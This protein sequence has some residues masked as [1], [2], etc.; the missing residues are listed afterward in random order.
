MAPNPHFEEEEEEKGRPVPLTTDDV[1]ILKAYG[2]GPFGSQIKELEEDIK[3]LTKEIAESCGVTESDTGIAPQSQWNLQLDRMRMMRGAL[4]VAKVTKIISPKDLETSE[5]DEPANEEPE[6]S[7]D[8]H[9]DDVYM[10]SLRH[11]SKF[12]AGRHADLPPQDIDE[13]MRVG[14]DRA[15]YQIKTPLPPPIDPTIAM[16]EVEER[17]D[18]TY[19]D[20]G[21]CKEQL[22]QL[23]E[24]IEDPLLHPERYLALGIDPPKGVLLYG[25]P[26]TGKTLSARAVANRTDS[27]FI[28]VIGSE[29]VQRFIG[30]GARMVRELFVMARQHSP[31][32]IFIDEVDSIATKRFDSKSGG[33]RE[34]QRTMLELL[35]QMDGFEPNA[36]IK[37]IMATNRIDILDRALL[38]PG[39][40]DRKIE[41]PNP[42][43]ASRADI[44]RIHSRQMNVVR[45]VDLQAVADTLE[46]ASGADLKAVCTEAGMYALRERRI[47]ITQHDFELAAAKVMQKNKGLDTAL[48]KLW[49]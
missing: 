36:N 39:R 11:S 27:C 30:E 41:F 16:M 15:R 29:L 13:D 2:S 8:D 10:I 43:S 5:S 1:A 22:R 25:P 40:I 17:P 45:G 47:H 32:I 12:V 28:R 9:E 18:V 14:I 20:I 21:G 34:V 6:D 46:G 24:V 7:V 48:E 38:R 37:V 4:H 35:N 3:K 49:K 44:L 26:G 19:E 42:G 31:S 23:R 33:D